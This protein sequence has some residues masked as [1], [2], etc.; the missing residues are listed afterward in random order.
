[1]TE[2]LDGADVP[3]SVTIVYGADG[4]DQEVTSLTGS[5]AD[6]DS[7]VLRLEER[8]T[9]EYPSYVV[10][11][12]STVEDLPGGA[13]YADRPALAMPPHI[14]LRARI[15]LEDGV[16]VCGGVPSERFLSY[17]RTQHGICTYEDVLKLGMV[18]L[19]GRG[20]HHHDAATLATIVTRQTRK[21]VG[22]HGEV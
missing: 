13:S 20:V 16:T 19:L 18:G 22:P 5:D 1:M 14:P 9:L 12:E 8:A 3:R 21:T 7:V 17:M 6:A 15:S 11:E 4:P 10:T 2:I